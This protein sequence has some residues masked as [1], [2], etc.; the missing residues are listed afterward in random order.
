MS[1]V[2]RIVNNTATVNEREPMAQC[3]VIS[4][5]CKQEP[6]KKTP[7]PIVGAIVVKDGI[8]LGEA[9]RGEFDPGDHAEFTLLQKKLSDIDVSG[10]TLFTT[11]EP[12][13]IRNYPKKP[14][15]EWI[16]ERGISRVVIGILDPNPEVCGLGQLM[17]RQARI[18]VAH[19]DADLVDVVESLNKEFSDEYPLDERLKSLAKAR[20]LGPNGYKIGYDDAGNKVEWIPDEEIPGEN[21][22]MIL[23]RNN[24]EISAMYHQ[25]WDMVWWSR[26]MRWVSRVETGAEKL[27]P[28]QK[29]IL[30]QAKKK[31]RQIEKKYGRENL[32]WND[33]EWG[34]LQG[35]MS[36]LSWV[37]G[38]NWEDSLDT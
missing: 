15:A 10:A 3:V 8:V 27:M 4:Q 35:K 25:C 34:L 16:I 23:L 17:L 9:F 37:M 18:Q 32:G 30:E 24:D 20:E 28:G 33:V 6:G 36:A 29:N 31:A 11:L 7:T 13:T 12:C 22:G 14:C 5:N 21:W 38:S 26:T 1:G 2:T 19:F